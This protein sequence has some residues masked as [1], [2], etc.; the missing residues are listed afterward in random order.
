MQCHR[1]VLYQRDMAQNH[2]YRCSMKKIYTWN[3]YKL[4]PPPTPFPMIKHRQK[5]F[6]YIFNGKWGGVAAVISR[7]PMTKFLL[8]FIFVHD[9]ESYPS[10]GELSY[11]FSW[12]LV[13]L[14]WTTTDQEIKRAKAKEWRMAYSRDESFRSS[15]ILTKLE[16]NLQLISISKQ[17]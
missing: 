13:M 4:A 14:I 3:P 7:G 8:W 2:V 5:S 12:T 10:Y 16:P 6:L 17:K 1:K 11:D 15:Q 9:F